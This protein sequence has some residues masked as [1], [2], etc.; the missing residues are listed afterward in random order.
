M[1]IELQVMPQAGKSPLGQLMIAD[2]S[3]KMR[4]NIAECA[5]HT[6]STEHKNVVIADPARELTSRFQFG[7]VANL[8]KGIRNFGSIHEID[9]RHYISYADT[10]KRGLRSTTRIASKRLT[11]IPILLSD[12]KTDRGN[13]RPVQ[14]PISWATRDTGT[15]FQ[16]WLI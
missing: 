4:T 1:G 8:D 15:R 5:D 6:V 3:A 7:D 10:V 13:S 12:V 9:L 14:R 2:R 11:G 16:G